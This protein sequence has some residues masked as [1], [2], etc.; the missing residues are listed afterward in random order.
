MEPRLCGTVT[1]WTARVLGTLYFCFMALFFVAHAL[2][3]DGLPRI[4]G[5]PLAIQLLFLAWFLMVLGCIVGW[6]W[7]GVASVMMLSGYSIW[8]IVEQRLPWPPSWIEPA[9]AI[10]LLYAFTWW[11]LKRPFPPQRGMP[12]GA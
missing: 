8:Q 9:L 2:S 3:L 4:G 12:S 1:R 10:G 5:E 11:Y 7:E 6:K